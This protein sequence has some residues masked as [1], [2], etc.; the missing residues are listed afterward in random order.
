MALFFRKI[1]KKNMKDPD[2]PKL[3]YPVLRSVGVVGEKE[4]GILLANET[5]LNPKE[6]EMAIH[7]LQKIDKL[8]AIRAKYA[9]IYNEAF[10]DFEGLEI[11]TVR[12]YVKTCWHLYPIKLNLDYIKVSRDQFIIEL[13]K[14]NIGTSVMFK[15]LHLHSYYQNNYGYNEGDF[16]ISEYLF[17]REIS[18]PISPAL[19]E[20]DILKCVEI[21][22]SLIKQNSK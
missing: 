22:I 1:Q 21:V 20:R 10:K 9:Q 15:P 11:P 16:P 18:L 6:A 19:S 4:L 12:D 3:W 17:D 7:Q 8:N 14:N 5:T 13:K 2:G